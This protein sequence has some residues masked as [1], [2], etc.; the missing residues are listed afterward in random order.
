MSL[1]RWTEQ[2]DRIKG[3][4][5]SRSDGAPAPK[6]RNKR[7]LIPKPFSRSS[8][9]ADNASVISSTSVSSKKS[10]GSRKHPS[11]S[12]ETETNLWTAPTFIQHEIELPKDLSTSVLKN[13]RNLL[14]DSMD[15]FRMLGPLKYFNARKRWS[16]AYTVQLVR[17]EKVVYGFSIQGEYMYIQMHS[18]HK[19][20]CITSFKI[21]LSSLNM[22]DLLKTMFE[23]EMRIMNHIF[24]LWL[25]IYCLSYTDHAGLTR[26]FSY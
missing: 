8:S 10:S 11:S 24:R 12:A 26:G 4:N 9:T 19:Y 20:I 23:Q 2:L 13:G 3:T 1:L 22:S 21:I 7:L 17:D 16:E 6:R 18:Y 15:P 14:V 5:N 25:M